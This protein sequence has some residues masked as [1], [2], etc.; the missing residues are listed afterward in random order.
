[1]YYLGSV[2]LLLEAF[3]DWLAIRAAL[4]I[5]FSQ[6]WRLSWEKETL[7]SSDFNGIVSRV[8]PRHGPL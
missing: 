8:G 7:V 1:M 5:P 6:L 4:A 3:R 2:A